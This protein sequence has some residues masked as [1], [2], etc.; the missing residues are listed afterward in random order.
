MSRGAYSQKNYQ[1]KSAKVTRVDVSASSTDFV[2]SKP[3]RSNTD[4]R[5]I[6]TPNLLSRNYSET[7]LATLPDLPEDSHIRIADAQNAISSSLP[8]RE[9]SLQPMPVRALPTPPYEEV[10]DTFED[11]TVEETQSNTS[12][13]YSRDSSSIYSNDSA[14]I[15]S[16]AS[17]IYSSGASVYSF[18]GG[19]RSPDVIEE[20]GD[21]FNPNVNGDPAV[22][23]QLD[24]NPKMLHHEK[25]PL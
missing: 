3:M 9:S 20:E 12:S 22:P 16:S 23:S 10:S 17:S 2:P 15:Y 1:V 24:E 25:P 18:D 8:Q 19:L 4:W 5:S 13:L 11:L 14:S 6:R 7:K 21:T